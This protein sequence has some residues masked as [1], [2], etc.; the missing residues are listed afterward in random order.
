MKEDKAGF[1]DAMHP[2][3]RCHG[4]GGPHQPEALASLNLVRSIGS[5]RG[6]SDDSWKEDKGSMTIS[7]WK[8]S[9]ISDAR[10]LPSSTDCNFIGSTA[11]H[12]ERD[13][14]FQT[15]PFAPAFLSG[16]LV[17]P[18]LILNVLTNTVTTINLLS[19]A[20]ANNPVHSNV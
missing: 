16:A 4:I 20:H 13:S 9:T 3:Q 14:N 2:V 5:V 10:W 11:S 6:C 17:E 19:G 15:I 7:E 1:E 18:K 12:S 8:T